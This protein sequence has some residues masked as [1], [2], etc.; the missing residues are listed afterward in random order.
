MDDLDLLILS[1]LQ[2]DGR[3]PFTQIAKRAGV[4]ESTIRNRY[5]S[6]VERGII[7]TV[8]IIDPFALGYRAPALIGINVSPGEVERVA[9]AIKQIPEASYLV[10]TLGGYNLVVEVFCRDVVHLTELITNQIQAIPGIQKTETLVVGKIY[11]LS[12]FWSP[13]PDQLEADN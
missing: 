13:E 4:A 5:T 2:E 7:Q 3:M 8:S 1:A 10:L 9:Q 12:F 11:K 6:L